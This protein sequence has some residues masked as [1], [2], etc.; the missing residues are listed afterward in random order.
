MKR[1]R[2]ELT[3][4]QRK[5]AC[6]AMVESLKTDGAE[7]LALCVGK[8]HWHA[9]VRTI[10]LGRHPTE[11]LLFRDARRIVGR[12]KGRSAREL[13]RCGEAP[14]GGVWAVRCRPIPIKN[15]AHQLRVCG[16]IPDHVKKG[17][18]IFCDPAVLRYSRR[19]KPR[20]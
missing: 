16:Y 3:P 15:R 13:S 4:R 6:D 10:P 20:A 2:V 17:A 12:A 19:K 14:E 7:V 11:S 18:A 8:K 9:L 1:R 5:I